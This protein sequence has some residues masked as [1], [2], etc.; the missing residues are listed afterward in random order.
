MFPISY[1]MGINNLVLDMTN[2]NLVV[3]SQG[4][5]QSYTMDEQELKEIIEILT[6]QGW[7]PMLCDTPIPV[8]EAVHAGNPADI[9]QIPA[10]MVLIPKALLSSNPEMLVRVIGDSMA[11][12][13]IADG[14]Y[15]KMVYGVPPRDGDIVVVVVDAECTIKSYYEDDEGVSWLV[16]QNEEKKNEYKIIRLDE[17][18]D[19]LYVC[20][21]VKEVLKAMPRVSVR[22]IRKRVNEVKAMY[23][24]QTEISDYQV[25]KVIRT[26]GEKITVARLWY[27]VYRVFADY[28]VVGEEDFNSFA[29]MVKEELPGHQHLPVSDEMQRMA[30]LS[31]SKSVKEW[32]ENNAPVKGKR[33]KD[34]LK[35]AQETENML[36]R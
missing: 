21:V 8:F 18:L 17:S 30:A 33:Y 27:A 29:D 10:D 14:D 15:V 23:E 1:E 36:N 20:G 5:T 28:N 6:Q 9:G 26:I 13:G 2:K 35:I 19:R 7:E 34:Y 3:P 4:K 32:N 22:S 31:F 11:D 16:P 12:V 24:K 25:R